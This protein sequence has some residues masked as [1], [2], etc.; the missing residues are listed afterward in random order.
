MSVESDVC[1]FLL[2]LQ[3]IST[4]A[5]TT[6]LL[7]ARTNGDVTIDD[8]TLEK[9]AQ[10]VKKTLATNFDAGITQVSLILKNSGI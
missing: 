4:N 3:E 7:A 1:R 5:V 9:V 8:A 6:D 2:D 10:V